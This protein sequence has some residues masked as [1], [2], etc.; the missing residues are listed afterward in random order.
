MDLAEYR[1]MSPWGPQWRGWLGCYRTFW[2]LVFSG[3]KAHNHVTI[4]LL[5]EIF[6]YPVSR[7]REFSQAGL[8]D[9]TEEKEPLL[10]L[11]PLV[12]RAPFQKKMTSEQD[13]KTKHTH[14]LFWKPQFAFH[15]FFSCRATSSFLISSFL[16]KDCSWGRLADHSF[17]S[18]LWL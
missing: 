9:F 1:V 12:F 8:Q 11:F 2:W 18:F 15:G 4:A 5:H 7:W 13:L 6:I 3:E 17:N 14:S 10:E 16:L